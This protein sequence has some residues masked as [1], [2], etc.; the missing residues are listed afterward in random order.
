MKRRLSVLVDYLVDYRKWTLG[1]FFVEDRW[2]M[3]KE[4]NTTNS[5][6]NFDNPSG[7]KFQR[8]VVHK[9]AIP[10]QDRCIE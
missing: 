5:N 1:V 10:G 8:A 7:V 3:K 2:Q 9:P 4:H 6:F